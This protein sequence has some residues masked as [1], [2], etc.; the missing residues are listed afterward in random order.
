MAVL[1]RAGEPIGPDE[2]LALCDRRTRAQH[3][4]LVHV[5]RDLEALGGPLPELRAEAGSLYAGPVQYHHPGR[6]A[7]RAGPSGIVVGQL[8]V[9]VPDP[10][11]ASDPVA[12]D[13]ALAQRAGGREHV[14]VRTAADVQRAVSRAVAMAAAG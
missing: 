2:V 13:A 3:R 1:E 11:T 7:D 6:A 10:R 12:A 9:D 8:L 4:A 14:V 5:L